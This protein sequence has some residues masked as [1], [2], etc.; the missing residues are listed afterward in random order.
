MLNLQRVVKKL[1][2]CTCY[3][4]AQISDYETIMPTRIVS[5]RE[6]SPLK[7]RFH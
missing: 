2:M 4:V 1:E 5:Y 3:T 7:F 6:L